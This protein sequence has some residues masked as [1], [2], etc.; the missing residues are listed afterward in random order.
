M[1]KAFSQPT[2]AFGLGKVWF[3]DLQVS[4]QCFGKRSD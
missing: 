1:N 2:V 4:F 3:L